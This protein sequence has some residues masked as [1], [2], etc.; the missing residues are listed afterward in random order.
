MFVGQLN[1]KG[2]IKLEGELHIG[3]RRLK[4]EMTWF[5]MNYIFISLSFYY[6]IHTTLVIRETMLIHVDFAFPF[7][8]MEIVLIKTQVTELIKLD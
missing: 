4:P 8:I 5:K 6:T 2:H 7:K 3:L 1:E